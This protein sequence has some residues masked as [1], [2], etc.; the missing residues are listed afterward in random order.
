MAADVGRHMMGA[1]L[2]FDQLHRG[3]D[4]PLRAAGAEAR[5]ARRHYIGE[6]VDRVVGEIANDMQ[7]SVERLL[8]YQRPHRPIERRAILFSPK[9][10]NTRKGF[11]KEM[12][13]LDSPPGPRLL[14]Y[15]RPHRWPRASCIAG[16]R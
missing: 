7:G 1:E 15:C 13:L 5:R 4:W 16:L 2:F 12:H 8:A 14:G 3:E 10:E 9:E 11:V 6:R